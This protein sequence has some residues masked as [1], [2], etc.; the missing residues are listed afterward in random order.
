MGNQ[1]DPQRMYRR[2]KTVMADINHYKKMKQ[3][4]NKAGMAGAAFY[5]HSVKEHVK[6]K[7]KEQNKENSPKP[8][9][10]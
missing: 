10:L 7:A 8:L 2:E 4:Y 5:A 9:N 1:I 3:N 6:Q